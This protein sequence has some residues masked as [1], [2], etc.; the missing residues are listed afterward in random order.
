LTPEQI[1]AR[2]SIGTWN[3]R[4]AEHGCRAAQVAAQVYD[5]VLRD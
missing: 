3:D 4:E 2:L 1:I 5:G